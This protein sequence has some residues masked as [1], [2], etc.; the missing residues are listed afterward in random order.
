MKKKITTLQK[1]LFVS[2]LLLGFTSCQLFEN[3]V[4]DFFEKYTETAAIEEHNISVQT[5]NDGL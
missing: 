2:A 1:L 3:D 5:Y 4:A